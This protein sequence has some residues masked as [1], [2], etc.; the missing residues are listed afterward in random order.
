MY[1]TI[2]EADAYALSVLETDFLRCDDA[3]ISALAD[4]SISSSA[5]SLVVQTITPTGESIVQYDLLKIGSEYLLVSDRSG[6]TLT[7]SRGYSGT[8]AAAINDEAVIAVKTPLK[9]QLINEATI[10]IQNL[11]KQYY[12]GASLLWYENNVDLRKACAMQA[13]WLAKYVEERKLA[14][15]IR[16]VTDSEYSDSVISVRYPSGQRYAPGVEDIVSDVT[17]KAGVSVG[18]FLRG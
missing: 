5:E 18:G 11:H 1:S 2:A 15:R 13:V 17:K 4:G 6:L 14:N 16:M 3:G 7:V 12:T 9:I 10:A 8:T